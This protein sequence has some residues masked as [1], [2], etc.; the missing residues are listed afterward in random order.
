[1]FQKV[2]G[3]HCSGCRRE[4]ACGRIHFDISD[5][6]WDWDDGELENLRV[7]A[8]EKPD[9]YFKQSGAVQTMLIDGMEFVMDCPC[10]YALKVETFIRQNAERIKDYLAQ[11]SKTLKA[12]ADAINPGGELV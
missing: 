1:M 12:K 9:Q 11:W 4:C 2:F 6:G 8:K 10:G 3:I 7:G 5:N